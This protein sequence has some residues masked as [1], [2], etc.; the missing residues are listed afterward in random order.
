MTRTELVPSEYRHTSV[1]SILEYMA[2]CAQCEM[3]N[4]QDK[5]VC[6]TSKKVK[7]K[8]GMGEVDMPWSETSMLPVGAVEG[9]SL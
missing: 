1:L 8:V 6:V 4:S 5:G 3:F 2:E 9:E 7:V